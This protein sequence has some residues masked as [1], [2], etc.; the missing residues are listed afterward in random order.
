MI[1]GVVNAHTE[2]TV[3][4]IVQAAGGREQEIEAILDTGFN[5]SL[6]L[7]PAVV[8][9]LGRSRRHRPLGWNGLALWSRRTHS[10]N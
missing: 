8:A 4:L 1:I 3:R 7:P 2:A 6:T 10:G 9:S 5:G